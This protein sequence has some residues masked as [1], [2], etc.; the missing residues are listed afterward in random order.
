MIGSLGLTGGIGSG[1]STVARILVG[2]G[3]HLV[4]TDAIAHALTAP[5][6]A[7]IPAISAAFGANMITADGALDRAAMRALAFNDAQ[8]KSR[9]EGLLHP[10][11]GA[12]AMRQA[13]SAHGHCVVFDVP[14]LG[15]RSAWRAHCERI[16]VVDCS[17]ATQ[18]ARV[19]ARSGWEAE[20]VQRVIAAQLPRQKRRAMADAVVC[21][22]GL[23]LADLEGLLA[24]LWARWRA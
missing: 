12:E 7:A 14:L 24:E 10:M 8:A 3:A 5:G 20:A 11:I 15:E 6:G 18:V 9:L 13:R 19:V 17:E 21:N 4:D 23:A 16:L 1:K 22:E 2:L